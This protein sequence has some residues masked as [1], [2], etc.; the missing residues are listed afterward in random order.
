M[1]IGRGIADGV[2]ERGAE[3]VADNDRDTTYEKIFVYVSYLIRIDTNNTI[4][5]NPF[6]YNMRRMIR[7]KYD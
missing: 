7:I 5:D 2:A 6:P 3:R 1:L 4:A